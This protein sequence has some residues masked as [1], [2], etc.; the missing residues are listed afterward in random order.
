MCHVLHEYPTDKVRT[1]WGNLPERALGDWPAYKAKILSLYPERD[2]EYRQSHGALMRLIRRQARMEIDRLSEFAEYNREFL[3]IAS[4][5]VKQGY[6]TEA[7]L[8]EYFADGIHRD[9]RSEA[10]S[11]LKRRYG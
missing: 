2:P 8:D 7:E 10:R 5:R 9:L 4:W 11:L 6:M 1:L 3:W